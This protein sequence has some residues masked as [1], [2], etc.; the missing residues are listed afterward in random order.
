MGSMTPS[1]PLARPLRAD[2]Q[3]NRDALLRAARAA[4][5]RDGLDVALEEIARRAGVSIGTLYNRFPGADARDA[6]IEAVFADRLEA[7]VTIAQEALAEPDPWAA[8]AGY[9]TGICALQAADRGF[10]QVAARGMPGSAA[11]R[12]LQARGYGLV[13]QI[14]SRAR[15]AGVLRGDVTVQ[16]LA[17]VVLGVSATIE[18]TAATG[19]ELWRRHL[20]LLLDG[21]RAAAAHPLPVPP[22]AGRA[23]QAAADG[24]P[25]PAGSGR[26]F[27]Q[28]Q[29]RRGGTVRF[30]EVFDM[31][32]SPHGQEVSG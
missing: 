6:L 17:F 23:H 2:A 1:G 27:N 25:G 16:D 21:F 10:R 9:V 24:A 3:R 29:S 31:S 7:T 22:A 18:A 20:G 11:A 26:R 13:A 19:P 8:F 32:S 5:A 12:D 30:P 28:S 14:M 4:F 15:D